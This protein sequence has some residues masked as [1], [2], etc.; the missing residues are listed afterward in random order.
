MRRVCI[1]LCILLVG[2]TQSAVQ[3]TS[4]VSPAASVQPTASLPAQVSGSPVPLSAF[5]ITRFEL[6]G[7][8]AEEWMI[9][10]VLGDGSILIQMAPNASAGRSGVTIATFDPVTQ[11]LRTVLT[12]PA[13]RQA[14]DFNGAATSFAWTEMTI[15]DAQGLDWRLHITDALT[16]A[17]RVVL[18]DPGVRIQ[19]GGPWTYNHKPVVWFDG[20][21]LLYTVFVPGSVAPS[22]E[23]RRL[24]DGRTET[25]TTIPDAST[26]V[27][28]RLTADGTGIAWIEFELPKTDFNAKRAVVVRDEGGALRRQDAPGALAIRLMASQVLIGAQGGLFRSARLLD[29]PAEKLSGV[30]NVEFIALSGNSIVFS[31]TSDLIAHALPA[32]GGMATDLDTGVTRGPYQSTPS[33]GTTAWFRFA[34]GKASIAILRE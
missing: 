5:S 10:G 34:D 3:P 26:N 28:A 31:G 30:L 18:T 7:L 8:R 23:L 25:L 6:P 24:V 29:K 1:A 21:T 19:G 4:A 27:L 12:L 22:T 13:G 11:R 15:G 17:D 2:C 32:S 14:G 20:K 16:G 9:A 33:T